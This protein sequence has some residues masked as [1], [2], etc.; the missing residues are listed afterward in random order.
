M[1]ILA[2]EEKMDQAASIHNAKMGKICSCGF[3]AFAEIGYY[4]VDCDNPERD[5]D[6]GADPMR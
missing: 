3:L 6:G 1:L 2:H 5:N 4:L